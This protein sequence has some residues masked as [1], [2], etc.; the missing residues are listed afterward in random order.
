[1][2]YSV[3]HHRR[4]KGINPAAGRTAAIAAKLPACSISA[5]TCGATAKAGVYPVAGPLYHSDRRRRSI[6][7]DPAMAAKAI[8]HGELRSER[9]C[10]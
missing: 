10:S 1:M 8:N 3:G 7:R 5:T 9:Y 4:R 2:L 6:F